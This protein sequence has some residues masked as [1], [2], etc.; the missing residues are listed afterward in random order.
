MGDCFLITLCE[1][2]VANDPKTWRGIMR[3]LDL[4]A[5]AQRVREECSHCTGPDKQRYL[6]QRRR[7]HITTQ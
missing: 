3:T 2:R 6:E 5:I 7:P 1:D 4:S